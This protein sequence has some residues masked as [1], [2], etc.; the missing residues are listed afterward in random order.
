[1]EE[2]ELQTEKKVQLNLLCACKGFQLFYET[3]NKLK[4]HVAAH[5]ILLNNFSKVFL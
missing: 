1:M 4:F 2:R 5:F 3:Q